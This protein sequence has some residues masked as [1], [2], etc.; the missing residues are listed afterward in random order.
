MT[1]SFHTFGCKLNQAETEKL[2]EKFEDKGFQVVPSMM[3][4]DIYLVNA[5]AVTQKAE[6]DV[7]QIIH[8]IR[9][10]APKS[11]LIVT[12]CFTSQIKAQE[13]LKGNVDIWINN[14]KKQAIDKVILGD[15]CLEPR[16]SIAGLVTDRKTRAL[17]KIQSGCQRYC[18]YCI[19]PYLRKKVYSRPI[20]QVIQEIKQKQERGWQEVVLVGTNIGAYDDKAE[21]LDLFGLLKQVLKKT[22]IPRIRLSSIWPTS[23]NSELLAL[24]KTNRRICPHVH[25]SIQ[26]ASDKI[27]KRMNRSYNKADL[28][29][30]IKGLSQIPDINLTADIIVGFPGEKDSDFHQ[31]LGFIQ[32]A[33]FLKIHVFRF[34]PRPETKAAGL[35]DQ[36][37]E[38]IKQARSKELIKKGELVSQKVRKKF[39]NQTV[40][41]LIEARQN[42]IWQGF[43]PNYLKVFVHPVRN[44]RRNCSSFD[45]SEFIS[46]GVSSDRNLANQIINV[47]LIDLYRNGIKGK[48][49]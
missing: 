12:G 16:E 35:K 23:V 32:W 34:S 44:L 40:S 17:I 46:N 8:Q 49:L 14:E 48:V 2:K 24:I 9:R 20:K 19:V 39:L 5:C 31:T 36:V 38:K 7:R 33:K 25:L 4:A 22:N 18:S 21:E 10:L 11:Y 42:E 28:E 26:S 47:K 13:E 30:I 43:T 41:V 15:L 3:A 29:R 6:K 27:L 45:K 37:L 1:I